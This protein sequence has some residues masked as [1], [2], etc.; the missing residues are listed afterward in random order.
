MI[1]PLIRFKL[2]WFYLYWVALFLM[3]FY[4]KIIIHEIFSYPYIEPNGAFI[5]SNQNWN[6]YFLFASFASFFIGLTAL[7][8]FSLF[9]CNRQIEKSNNSKK[10]NFK[11]WLIVL[12][13]ILILLAIN[14]ILKIYVIGLKPKIIFPFY[15]GVPISYAIYFGIPLIL[16]LYISRDINYYKRMRLQVVFIT[17]FLMVLLSLSV[18][19]RA[20]IVIYALPILFGGTYSQMKFNVYPV[21]YKPYG[22]AIIFLLLSL[23]LVSMLRIIYFY[24]ESVSDWGLIQFYFVEN[25]RLFIDRWT[26]AESLMVGVSYPGSSFATLKDLM[27]DVPSTG[28]AGIYQE[29]SGSLEKY[30]R[31]RD[32]EGKVFATLPGYLGILALSGSYFWVSFGVASLTCLGILYEYF[33]NKLIPESY[34]LVSLVAAAIAYFLTQVNFPFYFLIFLVN[35]AIILIAFKY[36]RNY[37]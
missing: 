37:K 20:P 33:A 17:L 11:E 4:I 15:L 18:G 29:I 26:G 31:Y 14:Y 25:L 2:S 6:N 16:S 23:I 35:T 7:I 13:P 34:P 19:S 1:A 9:N 30:I 8:V 24:E 10:I 32:L 36:I 22:Y 3:G 5:G 12:M 28:H 27:L 21:S